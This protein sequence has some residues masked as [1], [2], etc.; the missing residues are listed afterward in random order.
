LLFGDRGGAQCLLHGRQVLYHLATISE[1]KNFIS[2]LVP[3]RE[4]SL[5]MENNK[6]NLKKW[7]YM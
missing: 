2:N 4:V 1:S 7:Q 6:I 5:V 3:Q